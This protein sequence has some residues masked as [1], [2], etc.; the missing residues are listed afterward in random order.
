MTQSTILIDGMS[1]SNCVNSI[2]RALNDLQGIDQVH[3]D[4]ANKQAV[5]SF[6]QNLINIE[7]IIQHIEA[8]GFD[9]Q[10]IN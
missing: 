10:S 9:A 3:V 6:N 1:C 2:T 8:L 7:T 4:L 5:V